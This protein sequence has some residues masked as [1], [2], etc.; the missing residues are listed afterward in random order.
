[1]PGSDKQVSQSN[2]IARLG[3]AAVRSWYHTE[4]E[5]MGPVKKPNADMNKIHSVRDTG[6]I[7]SSGKGCHLDIA[8]ISACR[9]VGA[10]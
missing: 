10:T 6:P 2:M 7:Y 4:T 5:F 9:M 8:S 3:I 1:M